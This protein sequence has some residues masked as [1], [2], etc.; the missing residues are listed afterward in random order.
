MAAVRDRS[1]TS[2]WEAAYLQF[3]TPE[4]E[5]RKFVRRL[6]HLGTAQWP[7]DSTVIE[8]FCGRG[9][10]I[11]ALNRLGFRRVY[12]IDL[13]PRLLALHRQRG[14][15]AAGDCRRLPVQSR[16]A[17][18]AVVHGGLHHLPVLPDDLELT[19]ADVR[20]ILRPGGLFV[21]VEPWRT[22]FLDF[23]HGVG[24]YAL[25]RRLSRRMNAL[26][27]MIEHERPTYQQWLAEPDRIQ[28]ILTAAFEPLT[29][30]HRWGKL[31]F[32]GRRRD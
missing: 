27:T 1:T 5:I 31:L 3:E 10:G 8:L 6:R 20:R 19:V 29:I 15:C 21:A 7:R 18:A 12:G 23:V 13:S 26:M 2:E 30:E 4:E 25:V 17:D 22:P 24:S 16:S 11:V 9:N 28:T 32:V 14:R